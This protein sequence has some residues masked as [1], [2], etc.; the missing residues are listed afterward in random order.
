MAL[1]L[2]FA[3]GEYDRTIPFRTGDV[4]PNNIDLEYTPQAPELTFLQQLKDQRYDV[5]E[6][7]MSAYTQMRVKGRDDFIA[8]PV[9]PSRVFRHSALYVRTDS[10][11]RHPEH[12]RGKRVGIGFY[13]MSGAVWARGALMDDYGVK[14]DE[15]TWI[16][17]MDLKASAGA[18]QVDQLADMVAGTK[19][20]KPKLEVML[21]TGEI[22]ALLSVHTPRAMA[23]NEGTVR[24]L[25]E[26]C[27]E[28]E[29]DY[30]RRT[31]IFPMMHTI[32][33]KRQTYDRDPWIAQS[34]FDAFSEA[35]RRAMENIY[36]T[37][38]LAVV[39]PF[40]VHDIERTRALMGMD[41]WPFGIEA[42]KKSITTFF[43][44]L[45]DQ[46]IIEREPSVTDLFLDVRPQGQEALSAAAVR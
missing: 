21:E 4:K 34:L 9:F 30:F 32:V 23:R 25:F 6:M 16:S 12:L 15:M 18:N 28:V 43:R 22:D 1:K 36:E 8:L 5:S 10:D 31:G 42:N 37:N 2:K 38:A 35:K 7:S 13:Q 46:G 17:G 29:E 45:K 41:Y 24:Y 27:R 20:S 11:I 19:Q 14:P 26:N 3:C 33:I 39:A 40:I 44:H